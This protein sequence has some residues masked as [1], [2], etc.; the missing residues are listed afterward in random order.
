MT[1]GQLFTAQSFVASYIEFFLKLLDNDVGIT[2]GFSVKFYVRNESRL[3]MELHREN[4]LV[5]DVGDSQPGLQL[6]GEGRD[7]PDRWTER[8]LVEIDHISGPVGLLHSGWRFGPEE[9]L[10]TCQEN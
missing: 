8:E 2:E 1:H 4:V 5:F 7:G 9:E 3:G 6:E 10:V